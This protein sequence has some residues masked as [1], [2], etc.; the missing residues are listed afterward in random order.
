MISIPTK[1][2]DPQGE[3][4][5]DIESISEICWLKSGYSHVIIVSLLLQNFN[6][7]MYTWNFQPKTYF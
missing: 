2:H 1:D 4:R 5:R 6:V 3:L 7:A